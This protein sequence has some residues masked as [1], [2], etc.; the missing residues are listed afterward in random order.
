M[1]IR[2]VAVDSSG[3]TKPIRT[4]SGTGNCPSRRKMIVGPR[5][6]QIDKLTETPV[7]SSTASRCL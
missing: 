3:N 1:K 5:L 2:P 6:P 7:L 4:D